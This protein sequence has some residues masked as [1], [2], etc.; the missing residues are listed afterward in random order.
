MNHDAI[1]IETMQIAAILT[2]LIWKYV[3]Y[4]KTNDH[5][6]TVSKKTNINIHYAMKAHLRRLWQEVEWV[7]QLSL[8]T[9]NKRKKTQTWHHANASKQ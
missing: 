8:V 6:T 2:S 7:I 5:C 9:A 3:G 4:H 1:M